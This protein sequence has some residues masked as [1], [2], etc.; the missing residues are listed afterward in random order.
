MIEAL[1]RGVRGWVS[2]AGTGLGVLALTAS[3]AACASETDE[4]SAEDMVDRS[5]AIQPDPVGLA[6][7]DRYISAR[8]ACVRQTQPQHIASQAEQ[9]LRAKQTQWAAM[10]DTEFKRLAL[11]RTCNDK[12]RTA[13]EHFP[14]CSWN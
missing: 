13:A 8:M 4:L 14:S 7:C 5:A 1:R 10:A 3:I 9:A 2:E 12:R 6:A 11:G